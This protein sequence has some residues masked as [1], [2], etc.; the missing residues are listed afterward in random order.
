MEHVLAS[1]AA[2]NSIHVISALKDQGFKISSYS[3]EVDVERKNEPPRVLT[4]VHIKYLING[5]NLN[6]SSLKRAIADAENNYWS[7]GLMLK[8]AVP[9]T[10]SFEIR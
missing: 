2:C 5:E 4:K 3:V 9:I 1:L 8:K 6:E 10:S 7:V